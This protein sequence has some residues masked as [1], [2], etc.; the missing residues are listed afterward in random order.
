[1]SIFASHSTNINNTETNGGN[2]IPTSIFRPNNRTA[3]TYFLSDRLTISRKRQLA[4]RRLPHNKGLMK[5][6]SHIK[7]IRLIPA[8]H[9]IKIGGHG[10]MDYGREVVVPLVEEIGEASKDHKL[11]IVTGGGVRV[12]HILDIGI[13]LG[14]PTGV[15]VSFPVK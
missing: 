5:S 13:D 1:M 6:H 3:F 11:L 2:S 12:R 9:I 7:P 10:A 4:G 8:L 15:P 14:M